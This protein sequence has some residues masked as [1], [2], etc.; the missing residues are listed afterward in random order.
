MGLY[1]GE[2]AALVSTIC[3]TVCSLSFEAAGKRVGSLAVNFLRLI[4]GFFLLSLYCYFLRGLFLPTDASIH[5]WIWLGLSGIV[6]LVLG[7]LFLFEAYVEIG[8]RISMLVLSASPPLT[9]ILGYFI[10]GEKLSI[11]SIIGMFITVLGICIVIFKKDTSDKIKLNHPIKGITFAFLGAFGQ[12]LGL[13]LSKIG[14][15]DYNAFAASQ[16][17]TIFGIL[18]FAILFFFSKKWTTLKPAIHNKYA[19]SFITLGAIFGPFIGVSLS[20]LAVQ[21]TKAGIVSTITSIVPVMIIPPSIFLFKEKITI[22]E[23]IGS[24]VAVLGVTILF[25]K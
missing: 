14:M 22:K 3:W 8:A 25:I 17:R 10:L 1:I 24:I 7:D 9:A 6:G 2:I 21:Y 11:I 16:I 4:I 20:L 13:I 19:M 5:T 12:S 15:A 18:G 23:I